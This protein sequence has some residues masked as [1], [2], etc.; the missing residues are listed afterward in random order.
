MNSSVTVNLNPVQEEIEKIILQSDDD[1]GSAVA[2][3]VDVSYGEIPRWVLCN[4]NQ[5]PQS[6]NENN[7][8]PPP[9]FRKCSKKLSFKLDPTTV[10]AALRISSNH[11]TVEYVGS[12]RNG[13]VQHQPQ[14]HP[15][16]QATS[17]SQSY[18]Y[19]GAGANGCVRNKRTQFSTVLGDTSITQVGGN[20][21]FFI[22]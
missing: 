19:S 10:A 9:S 5:Y 6:W 18:P 17:V 7:L 16:T 4:G 22:P 14:I 3:S 11:T 20:Y 2:A 12:A 13:F 1:S 21:K 15:Q 8:I